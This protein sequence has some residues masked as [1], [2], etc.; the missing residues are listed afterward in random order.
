MYVPSFI[1][2]A[3]EWPGAS[4]LSTVLGER[5]MYGN[6]IWA[7][8]KVGSAAS[9]VWNSGLRLEVPSSTPPA[10]DLDARVS[11]E[12]DSQPSRAGLARAVG[13]P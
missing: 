4:V 11:K 13:S 7:Y 8:D 6:V 9:Y 3:T 1:V 10:A 5:E 2:I 12:A